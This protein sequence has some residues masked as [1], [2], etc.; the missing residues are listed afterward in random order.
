MGVY[1][2]YYVQPGQ[3]IPQ[4][5]FDSKDYKTFFEKTGITRDEYIE[6]LRKRGAVLY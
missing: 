2:E 4:Y 1:N 5:L 3:R 6:K